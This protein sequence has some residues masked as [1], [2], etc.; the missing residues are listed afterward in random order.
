[1][2]AK[3]NAEGCK[4]LKYIIS[5]SALPTCIEDLLDALLGDV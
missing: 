1:M 4:N 5:I 3:H 2:R